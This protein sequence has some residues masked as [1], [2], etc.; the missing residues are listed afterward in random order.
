MQDGNGGQQPGDTGRE[1][2]RPHGLR[3]RDQDT[4]SCHKDRSF[5][6]FPEREGTRANTPELA[7]TLGSFISSKLECLTQIW[8]LEKL[9][10]W[11]HPPNPALPSPLLSFSFQPGIIIYL[12]GDKPEPS[13]VSFPL[14]TVTS[15][16]C[17]KDNLRL[18]Q[19][20]WQTG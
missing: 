17:F 12:E 10:K 1:L 8:E 19:E 9:E 13:E 2:K 16:K 4:N 3:R 20:L 11:I 15:L 5:T 14:A 7:P 6:L 18:S